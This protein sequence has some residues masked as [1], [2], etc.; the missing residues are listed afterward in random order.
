MGLNRHLD[1]CFPL[2]ES[3]QHENAHVFMRIYFYT[4][5][6]DACK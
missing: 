6:C 1:H 2:H 4:E 3:G 5:Y